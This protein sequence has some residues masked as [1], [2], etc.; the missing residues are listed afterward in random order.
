MQAILV[1]QALQLMQALHL[2]ETSA[3]P[4]TANKVTSWGI[5]IKFSSLIT[6]NGH[7]TS[8]QEAI[9]VI[10]PIVIMAGIEFGHSILKIILNSL[11]PSILAASIKVSGN[12]F[13]V[14]P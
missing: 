6:I 11:Q 3:L 2:A 9:K 10:M 14:L 8:F 1:V 5:V 12:G 13:K 7:R 4:P